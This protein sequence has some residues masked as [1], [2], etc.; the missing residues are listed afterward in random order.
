L[1]KSEELEDRQVD[2]RV[3]AETTLIRAESRVKLH[4]I[5]TVYVRLSLIVFPDNAELDDTLWHL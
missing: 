1:L 2:A 3:K 4:T 5:A